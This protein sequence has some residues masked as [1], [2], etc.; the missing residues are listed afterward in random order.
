VSR[1]VH[2]SVPV[3]D[4]VLERVRARMGFKQSNL[5]SMHRAMVGTLLD[6]MG[7]DARVL[8]RRSPVH[9]APRFSGR[10]WDDYSVMLAGVACQVA[11]EA[12]VRMFNLLANRLGAAGELPTGYGRGRS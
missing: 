6:G 1:V 7:I 10:A 3:L 11:D 9:A 5:V 4:T 8:I 12:T 2:V